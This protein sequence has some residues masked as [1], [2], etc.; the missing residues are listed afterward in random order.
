MKEI[1]GIDPAAVRED[2]API[3]KLVH[4]GDLDRI[5]D[6]IAASA[7]TM[8]PWQLP[9]FR[10]RHPNKGEIWIEGIFEPFARGR[11]QHSLARAL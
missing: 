9:E 7:Q 2:A 5:N 3:L 6:L 8:S 4:P 11:W 10:Y 1:Y